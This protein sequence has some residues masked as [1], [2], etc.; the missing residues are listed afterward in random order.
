MI[1]LAVT[2]CVLFAT[3]PDAKFI[4]VDPAGHFELPPKWTIV[5]PTQKCENPDRFDPRI[6]CDVGAPGVSIDGDTIKVKC[7]TPGA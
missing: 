4:W 6:W 7:P 3:Y 5:S 2:A 1:E